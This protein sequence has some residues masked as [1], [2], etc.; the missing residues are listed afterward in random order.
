LAG[1][2]CDTVCAAPSAGAGRGRALCSIVSHSEIP[3]QEKAR[4]RDRCRYYGEAEQRGMAA[5][6]AANHQANLRDRT[7]G[8]LFRA[9][10]RHL[11]QIKHHWS[12]VIEDHILRDG[13]CLREARDAIRGQL[14]RSSSVEQL[15]QV[16]SNNTGAGIVGTMLTMPARTF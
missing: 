11:T 7:L 16:G 15:E 1:S 12:R 13:T 3:R 6:H 2:A 8:R 5:K 9:Q 10:G 14:F 4:G